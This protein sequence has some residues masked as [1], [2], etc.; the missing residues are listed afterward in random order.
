MAAPADTDSTLLNTL[1]RKRE[2]NDRPTNFQIIL[3]W[4]LLEAGL[5]YI[6]FT[7][8]LF[9]FYLIEITFKNEL[10]YLNLKQRTLNY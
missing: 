3:K 7:V 4:Q 9:S 5:S 6:K 1:Q 8:S 2:P 10:Y